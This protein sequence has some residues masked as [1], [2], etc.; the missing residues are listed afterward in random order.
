MPPSF[1][2]QPVLDLARALIGCTLSI[3]GVGGIIV[4]TEAYHAA[5]PASHSFAG[6]T[7]RN[8]AMWGPA[9][10]TYIYRIYGMH[11]CLN[12]VGGEE[13]GA[14]VLLR[15]LEPTHGLAAMQ[16][17]RGIEDAKALCSGPG[18]LC[19][20]LAV[21]ADLDGHSL[22]VAPFSLSPRGAEP[23]LVTGP[24]IGIT[25]AAAEPWRFGLAGS[26]FLSR[27]FPD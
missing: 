17:R 6:P 24:R 25:K 23:G 7:V 16:A 19:Q 18:K 4:E 22:D 14:A 10:R 9:G 20:A 5:D 26:R 2:T 12:I 21:S 3:D 27:R 11:W 15:A 1:Y 13:P 8:R